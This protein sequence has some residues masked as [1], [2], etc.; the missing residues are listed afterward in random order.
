MLLP[1]SVA[2]KNRQAL[3]VCLNPSRKKKR[4]SCQ[5]RALLLQFT[6]IVSLC[7]RLASAFSSHEKPDAENTD[8]KSPSGDLSL[9]WCL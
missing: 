6:Q 3:S 5:L 7:H 9:S 2:A 4:G 8:F 1:L